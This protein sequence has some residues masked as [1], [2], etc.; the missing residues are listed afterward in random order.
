MLLCMVHLLT[1]GNVACLS[2]HT[3]RVD[4]PGVGYRQMCSCQWLCWHRA[5]RKGVVVLFPLLGGVPIPMCP[6]V[7][8]SMCFRVHVFPC[9]RLSVVELT[10]D[11]RPHEGLCIR[12]PSPIIWF[13]ECTLVAILYVCMHVYPLGALWGGEL[14]FPPC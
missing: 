14:D 6:C 8:V 13:S 10:C 1:I 7:I 5:F 4:L 3:S 12:H 11:L 9:P 2:E